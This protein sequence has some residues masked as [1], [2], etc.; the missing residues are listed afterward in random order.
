MTGHFLPVFAAPG[1]PGGPGHFGVLR[2]W[3]ASLSGKKQRFAGGSHFTCF[4]R[5]ANSCVTACLAAHMLVM[6]VVAIGDRR[7]AFLHAGAFAG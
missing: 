3:E 1:T 5:T 6:S 4:M 7:P 2:Q